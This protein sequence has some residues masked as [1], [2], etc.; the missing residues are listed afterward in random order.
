MS[1]K[2]R[3]SHFFGFD[4]I[5][6]ETVAEIA[7]TKEFKALKAKLRKE[8][9]AVTLTESFFEMLITQLSELLNIDVRTILLNTWNKSSDILQYTDSQKYP[10]DEIFMLPLAQHTITSE[11]QP[12]LQLTLNKAP[13]GEIQLDIKLELTIK[14]GILKIQNKRIMAFSVGTCQ[15]KG[16]VRYGELAL[17]ERKS[18]AFTLPGTFA[19]G[20]GIALNDTAANV[21]AI[22]DT[23]AKA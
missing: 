18:G 2:T 13:V 15:G 9:P 14:G 5:S 20:A 21:H 10:P 11:H 17:L 12:S 19:L 6:K 22:V 7:G 3:L 4:T 23:I 8:L 16:S 1:G